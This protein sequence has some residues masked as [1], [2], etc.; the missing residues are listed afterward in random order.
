MISHLIT[1][2]IVLGIVALGTLIIIWPMITPA[3]VLIIFYM[4]VHMLVKEFRE[5]ED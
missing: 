5:N 3:I 2:G 1:I 4:F